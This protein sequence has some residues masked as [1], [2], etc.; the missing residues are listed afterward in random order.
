MFSGAVETALTHH[1][2][3]D[4]KGYPQH[5]KGN[6]LSH[7]SNL[8]AVVDMYDAITSDRVYQKAGLIIRQQ[9]SCWITQAVTSTTN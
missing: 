8:V 7:Y 5:I 9:K 1:E 2:H 4:G 3:I 6:R